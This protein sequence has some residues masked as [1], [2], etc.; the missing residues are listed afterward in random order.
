[1][2]AFLLRP[3]LI[4]DS[5]ETVHQ[6]QRRLFFVV[7]ADHRQRQI[8]VVH[9]SRR[10]L[11]SASLGAL[12]PS[13]AGF[14]SVQTSSASETHA[15]TFFGLQRQARGLQRCAPSKRLFFGAS[16]SARDCQRVTTSNIKRRVF[17]C[18]ELRG[19][20]NGLRR[21]RGN[22]TRKRRDGGVCETD[23]PRE[24]R[25]PFVL[26]SNQQASILRDQ[27]KQGSKIS[28]CLWR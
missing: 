2:A 28:G 8:L 14:M 13:S 20:G 25:Y 7:A 21:R 5:G 26:K 24:D 27:E 12:R 18:G 6:S 9:R 19:R 10:R 1:M 16:K 11:P 23:P 17:S 22:E 4:F 3:V 15:R